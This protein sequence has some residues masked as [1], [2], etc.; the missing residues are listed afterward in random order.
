MPVK[1][2]TVEQIIAKLREIEKLTRAGISVPMGGQKVGSPIDPV[3]LADRVRR[4]LRGRHYAS[5]WTDGTADEHPARSHLTTTRAK[6]AARRR[7]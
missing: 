2:H 4:A 7:T 3:S 5:R 1:K 6:L